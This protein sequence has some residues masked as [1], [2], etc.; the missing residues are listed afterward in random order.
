MILLV[1]IILNLILW[2]VFGFL[3]H[4]RSI[5]LRPDSLYIYRFLFFFVAVI[6]FLL[7]RFLLIFLKNF[8][9]NRRLLETIIY[10]PS[11]II[12]LVGAYF[13]VLAGNGKEMLIFEI[14]SLYY[15][16]RH[17]KLVANYG[18]RGDNRQ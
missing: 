17:Y 9:H 4:Y 8:V 1:Y 13:T 7:G 5:L 6:V 15:L 16:M 10:L 11:L 2:M 14:T 18:T 3:I 12:T